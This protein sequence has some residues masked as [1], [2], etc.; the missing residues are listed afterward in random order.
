MLGVVSSK[1]LALLPFILR[2]LLYFE[3]NQ[4]SPPVNL[5]KYTSLCVTSFQEASLFLSRMKFCE[6]ANVLIEELQCNETNFL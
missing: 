2:F 1:F 3:T 6:N 5:Q 4:S